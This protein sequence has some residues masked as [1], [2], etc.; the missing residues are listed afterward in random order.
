[1]LSPS[2]GD[3]ELVKNVVGRHCHGDPKRRKEERTKK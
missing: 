1:M 2:G 3:D